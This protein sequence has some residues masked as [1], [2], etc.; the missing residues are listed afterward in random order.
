MNDLT[1]G[2]RLRSRP[3]V[4]VSAWVRTEIPEMSLVGLVAALT[5]GGVEAVAAGMSCV[6]G[7][8][9]PGSTSGLEESESESDGLSE[10]SL[11]SGLGSLAG[12]TVDVRSNGCAV[13]TG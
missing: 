8:V 1:L 13:P 10:E 6:I 9:V 12:A 2:A 11:D 5:V 3:D 4:G 7:A